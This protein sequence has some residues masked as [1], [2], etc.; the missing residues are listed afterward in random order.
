MAPPDAVTRTGTDTT[1]INTGGLPLETSV[2]EA[3]TLEGAG[4]LRAGF[5]AELTAALAAPG[6]KSQDGKELQLEAIESARKKVE[7]SNLSADVK[8]KLIKQLDETKDYLLGEKE[9]VKLSNLMMEILLA[10]LKKYSIEPGSIGIAPLS[11]AKVAGPGKDRYDAIAGG[12]R[13]GGG[14]GG[15]GGGGRAGRS[16]GGGY[17]GVADPSAVAA[18]SAGMPASG[19]EVFKYLANKFMTERGS[20]PQKAAWQAAGIVG[21]LIQESGLNPG[22]VQPNGVGHGLAQW[23]VGD[24]WQ[25]L[26]N[27]AGGRDPMGLETQLDFIFHEF[28]TTEQ[29]AGSDIDTASSAEDA[30]Y[31]FCQSYERCGSDTAM[32]NVRTSAAAAAMNM[33]GDAWV[34]TAGKASTDSGGMM[35]DVLSQMMIGV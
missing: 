20:D 29:A 7:D 14:G 32:M 28:D 30:A 31:K 8:K 27:F 9:G 21:N 16:G 1:P 3:R 18:A 25:D 24:R 6:D 34:A 17:F 19:E 5:G 4:D 2:T 13:T 22:A 35:N 10:S 33:Y 23:S 15:G 11:A 12:G 26:L